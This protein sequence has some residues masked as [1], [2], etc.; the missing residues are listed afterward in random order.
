MIHKHAFSKDYN[1][2]FKMSNSQNWTKFLRIYLFHKFISHLR[3]WVCSKLRD[4]KQWSRYECLLH[5]SS[6]HE[7]ST[8]NL[9]SEIICIQTQ[10][11]I[12]LS[13]A[14]FGSD[15]PYANRAGFDVIASAMGG[16]MHVTGPEVYFVSTVNWGFAFCGCYCLISY[17]LTIS[18]RDSL[19]LPLPKM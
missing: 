1:N 4:M 7:F 11:V 2:N 18:L 9:Q 12:S 19:P 6:V 16:L 13:F 17:C 10:Y 14:G 15:G 3:K 8:I 5:A